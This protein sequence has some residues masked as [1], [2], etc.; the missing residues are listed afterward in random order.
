IRLREARRAAAQVAESA[1]QGASSRAALEKLIDD[2]LGKALG[3]TM[4]PD[5]WQSVRGV[6]PNSVLAVLGREAVPD[7]VPE[8]SFAVKEGALDLVRRDISVH[9][10]VK[11][12]YYLAPVDVAVGIRAAGEEAER[13]ER[14]AKEAGATI[15]VAASYQR[16]L[17][18]FFGGRP[19]WVFGLIS[20]Q[21]ADFLYPKPLK[22]RILPKWWRDLE[23]T[24]TP[25]GLRRVVQGKLW[26]VSKNFVGVPLGIF[27]RQR[28]EEGEYVSWRKKPKVVFRPVAAFSRWMRGRKGKFAEKFLLGGL[29]GGQRRKKKKDYEDQHLPALLVT[30][31]LTK[32]A[33]PLAKAFLVSVDKYILGGRATKYWGLAKGW[34]QTKWFVLEQSGTFL[35]KLAQSLRVGGQF[36]GALAGGWKGGA[37]FGIMG[38]FLSGGNPL[39]A[40]LAGGVGWAAKSLSILASSQ[41]FLGLAT[42]N[43]GPI[44]SLARFLAKFAG[45]PLS[46]GKVATWFRLPIKGPLAGFGIGYVIG[47]PVGGAIGAAAG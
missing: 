12:D 45:A 32:V 38:Y 7:S 5:V 11:T 1:V 18:D 30:S 22:R 25:A 24:G 19:Q 29:T 33:W 43:F 36:F 35:G 23:K 27:V 21:L 2:A 8:F 37:G 9:G 44:S 40:Y 34:V 16:W 42:Q 14:A 6:L 39:V 47:G 28:D 4:A 17:K 3:D 31:F 41:S 15:S 46:G 10:E 26:A 20:P 13:I